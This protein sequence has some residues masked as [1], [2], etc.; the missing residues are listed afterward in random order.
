LRSAAIAALARVDYSTDGGKSW[1]QAQL[2]KDE[3]NYGF[4]QWQA[5]LTLPSPGKYSLLTRCHQQQRRRAARY[6][7]LES[8]RLH[9]QRRG[10]GRC[11]GGLREYLQCSQVS[12]AAILLIAAS[13][14]LAAR[15]AT[16]LQLKSVKIDLPDSDKMFPG[17]P[18]SDAIN[19][20]CLRL[21][22]G[23]HGTEPAGVVEASLAAEVNR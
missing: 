6:T 2:G 4:R 18:G 21:S 22:L 1:Q 10:I 12:R 3:G 17:G 8:R 23:R 19:N 20:N 16:P 13:M 14:P 11:V 15:A 5:Q 7:Q 9:A